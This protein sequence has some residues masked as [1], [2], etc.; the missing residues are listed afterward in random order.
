MTEQSAINTLREENARLQQRLASLEA[1]QVTYQ[2]LLDAL[3]A[4][5]FCKD[6]QGTILVVNK[7]YEA[8]AGMSRE[9]MLGKNQADLF[10]PELVADWQKREQQ[11]LATGQTV[12]TEEEYPH[13]DGMHTYQSSMVP[14]HNTQ[15][16]IYAFGGIANNISGQKA[17]ELALLESEQR[18]RDVM[19]AAGEYIWEIDTHARYTFVSE[20]VTDILGYSRSE[21][22]GNTP[23]AF[24]PPD[25]AEP[26]PAWYTDLLASAETFRDFYHRSVRKD[27]R[28]ITQRVS[29]VPIWQDGTLVGYRG[30]GLDVTEQVEMQA[31]R[32]RMQ[33]ERIASQ[34]ATLRELSTP[35]IPISENVVIMPLIGTIDSQRAQLVMETL[36]EGVAHY[37]AEIALLDITGVQTVDTQVADALVRAAQ[38]VKLLGAQVMLTGIQPQ[39]AQMLVHLGVDLSAIDTRGSLQA[40][41]AAVLHQH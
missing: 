18:F 3:P 21:V 15:G 29:G 12:D 28:I 16:E 14:L 36:L 27:G 19:D 32:E 30:T 1:A 6:T 13:P 23:A 20:R 10:P 2:Q 38:A 22:L 7:A 33:E 5:I 8:I 17:R 9:Q 35:L 40:G 11:V 37:Q 25:E 4:I 31:E 39:I 24:M 26:F 41:I 34:Q